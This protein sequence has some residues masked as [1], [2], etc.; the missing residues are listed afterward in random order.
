VKKLD[1]VTKKY[2][3]GPAFFN[4]IASFTTYNGNFEGFQ[5]DPRSIIIDYEGLQLEREF[6]A[7]VYEAEQQYQ[8]RLPDFRNTLLWKPHV[9]TGRN[10]TAALSLYT[11]DQKGRYRVVIEGMDKKGNAVAT[12]VPIEVN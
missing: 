11:S 12:H 2:F 6:Y 10:G 5:L 3:V 8:S 9:E 7:P 1:V 4:G